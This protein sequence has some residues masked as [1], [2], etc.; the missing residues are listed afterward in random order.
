MTKQQDTSLAGKIAGYSEILAK[1]PYSTVFVPLSDAYRQCGMPAEALQVALQGVKA[2]PW[3]CPGYEVLGR[4][5]YELGNLGEAL[6]AFNKALILD[7]ESLTALK[8][9]ARVYRSKNL[10]E[11]ARQ[12]LER[13][14][15]LCP[16]NDSV[17]HMLSQ[18]ELPDEEVELEAEPSSADPPI[19]TATIAELF[20]RQ[21]LLSQACQ[22]YRD[23]LQ[24]EP[25]NE[26]VRQKLSAL[27]RELAGEEPEKVADLPVE[28]V[29]EPPKE[30]S[31]TEEPLVP[32]EPLVREEPLV[33]L[34]RWLAT[35]RRRREQYVS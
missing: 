22:V 9:L 18:L 6:R 34:Q 7:G 16:E 14:R 20:V 4:A 2:L 31:V 8:G 29:Q 19:A 5:H 33:V 17:R 30:N 21:G 13:A 28:N 3:F 27:E 26:E 25:E 1:D 24:V 12:V 23:I 15:Q 35:I 11:P 10:L 32:E